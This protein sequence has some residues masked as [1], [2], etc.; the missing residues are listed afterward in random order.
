M[1][2]QSRGTGQH[3]VGFGNERCHGY[4]VHTQDV[5]REKSISLIT[6]KIL[7]SSLSFTHGSLK[8]CGKKHKFVWGQHNA[9]HDINVRE[10]GGTGADR[11]ESALK[12]GHSGSIASPGSGIKLILSM[13]PGVSCLC[14]GFDEQRTSKGI[15]RLENYR[16]RLERAP[17]ILSEIRLCMTTTAT[18]QTHSRPWRWA[19]VSTLARRPQ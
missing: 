3:L 8:I 15:V 10:I 13:L 19:I 17:A 2:Y 18:E 11:W 7:A 14:V 5:G 12:V 4:L 16:K 6:M 9:P 1:P